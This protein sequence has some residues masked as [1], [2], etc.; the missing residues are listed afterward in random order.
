M[1]KWR[2]DFVGKQLFTKF[3]AI[4]WKP[5]KQNWFKQV[6]YKD[7]LGIFTASALSQILFSHQTSLIISHLMLTFSLS[8][9]TE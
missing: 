7:S 9:S 3:M 4:L 2:M 8:S 5:N 1:F 6:L